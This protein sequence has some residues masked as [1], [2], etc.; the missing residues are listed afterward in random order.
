MTAL[1]FI[2][3]ALLLLMAAAWVLVSGQVRSPRVRLAVSI[4]VVVFV[5]LV[6]VVAVLAFGL[7]PR[8]QGS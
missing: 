3:A 6:A 8:M 4:L 2:L 5:A 7:G 1:H